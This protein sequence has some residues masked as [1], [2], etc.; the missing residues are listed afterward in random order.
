M[1]IVVPV[2]RL[3]SGAELP[4][5]LHPTI[6]PRAAARPKHMAEAYAEQIHNAL[7]KVKA[8]TLRIWESGSAR[9]MTWGPFAVRL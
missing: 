1:E 5:C 6:I 8:G 7:P 4:M 2:R 9:P 3:R